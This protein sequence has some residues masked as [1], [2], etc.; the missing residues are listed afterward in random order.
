MRLYQHVVSHAVSST[1]DPYSQH[2]TP[3][4][5]VPDILK[6]IIGEENT[7]V[8]MEI[9]TKVAKAPGVPAGVDSTQVVFSLHLR[10]FAVTPFARVF[11]KWPKFS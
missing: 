11:K 3:P 7:S 4:W 9:A 8:T 6:L 10:V 2:V 1:H 5:Q